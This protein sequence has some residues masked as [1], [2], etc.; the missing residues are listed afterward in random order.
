MALVASNAA[1]LPNLFPSI[2]RHEGLQSA[3]WVLSLALMKGRQ[4]DARLLR[5]TMEEVFKASDAEGAWGWKDAYEAVE[6]AQVYY[7]RRHAASF[8]GRM[9]NPHEILADLQAIQ[10]LT[11]SQTRRSEDQ[12]AFQQFST[13]IDLAFVASMALAARSS[14]VVLEP[15]AGTGMLAIFAEMAGSKVYL[16]ELDPKRAEILAGAFR[17]TR[18]TQ[19]NA[20]QIND[21]LDQDIR[22]NLVLMNPPFSVSPNVTGK[23]LGADFRHIASALARLS[24]GGR[25]V[26]ITGASLSPDVHADKFAALQRRGGRLAFSMPID[27]KI[28]ARHGTSTDTRLTIIDKV[29]CENTDLVQPSEGMARDLGTLL[30]AVLNAPRRSVSAPIVPVRNTFAP[31]S[32]RPINIR[33]VAQGSRSSIHVPAAAFSDIISVEYSALETATDG[34]PSSTGIYETYKVATIQIAGAASHPTPLVESAAMSAVRLPTPTYQP[35]LPRSVIESGLLSEAQLETIIYAGDAHSTMLD[36][37]WVVSDSFDTIQAAPDGAE[38]AVAFRKGFFVGDGTGVGKG[39]QIAGALLDN[40]LQGRRR[41]V[42]V[43]KNDTLLED[44]QR[45]WMALGGRKEQI[46]PLSR[47]AQGSKI[48]LDEAI[49]FVTYGTL[50]TG[51]KA[52][53]VSRLDQIVEWFGR[54]GDGL[55]AFDEAHAMANAAGEKGARGDRKPSEQ[56]I[57]GLRLQN[58]LPNARI[59]YV[60]ATGATTVANLGYATRLGLWGSSDFP[61]PT[62]ASFVCAMEAGGVAAMEVMARDLKALGLYTARSLSYAGVEYEMLVHDLTADQVEIYDAYAGA[63]KIIQNNLEDALKA[64]GICSQDGATQNGNAKG[65]ARSAFESVKQRFFSH[66]L[67]AMKVPSVIAAIDEGLAAGMAPVIQ[68]VSTG[69]ALTSRRLEA[70]PVAEWNDIQV[71]VTPREYVMDYLVHSFPTTLF[72]EYSDDDGN[73][74]SRPVYVDG[75]PLVCQEAMEQRDALMESLGALPP[76]QAALDQLIQ[77]YGADKISEVTGRSRRIVRK[78]DAYGSR[79]CVESRPASSNRGETQAFMDGK[80]EILVFSDAGGTGRSYHADLGAKNQKRRL[81]LLL[82]P[83]WNASSA[84]QG[85]GRTNRTNQAQPPLFRPVA[86]NVKG[87]KR[88]LS[89]IA[90]RLDSLGAITKGQRQTGGQGLFRAEDNLE[91]DYAKTALRRLF[92]MLYAG[93]VEGLS[94]IEFEE[95]TGLE[96]RDADGTLKESL[97]PIT[98]TLNRLLALPIALQDRLFGYLEERIEAEVDAAVA[99]GQFEIGVE[100]LQAERFTVTNRQTIFTHEGSG[101]ETRLLTIEQ[102]QRVDPVTLA[103]ALEMSEDLFSVLMVNQTSGR[104]AIVTKAASRMTEDG[105]VHPRVRLIR[106]MS[107][108]TMSLEEQSSSH[109]E[110]ADRDAFAAAWKAELDDLPET[111]TTEFHVVTGLLLPIWSRLPQ[112]AT[113]VYRLEANGERII[114]RVVR[115]EEY[116]AMSRQFGLARPTVSVADAWG[117]VLSSGGEIQLADGV[118]VRRS[119]VAG[120]QRVEVQNYPHSALAQLKALGLTTEIIAY[121]T[122]LFIPANDSGPA[123]LEAVMKRHPFVDARRRQGRGA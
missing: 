85:L 118:S 99:S 3:G 73:I 96:L 16:N 87:E 115:P 106:P 55:I 81:H 101:A 88:F 76:V 45:D 93:T 75:Q 112:E 68:L 41:L 60:S 21:R 102:V 83:G 6:L 54:D 120:V 62:R 26:A 82:E 61:F 28:Y 72:E 122:R 116:G 49:L 10:L 15:S 78:E 46:V 51:A 14:D 8:L 123:L 104:A 12:V 24:D 94:L 36:G 58:A 19:H 9:G 84:V 74:R 89:T 11:P 79:L 105:K 17:D 56:G 63:F 43:S 38:N 7:L 57:A 65:A 107:R 35:R 2:S 27:G 59:L 40:W 47:F 23:S 90:R 111:I 39:R 97:P 86:T 37:R 92:Q 52:D 67:C 95:A 4:I 53:K 98:R 13:P 50:R 91:S 1:S 109:W 30:D 31:S 34:Q 121:K 69:E 22:P 71:D 113:R 80:K 18:V 32:L 77:H 66:L 33:P 110:P 117:L 25:L 44:A 108:E 100:T 5:T 114:G 70:I 119:L 103:E 48:G 29:A 20:E 64:T 42:W